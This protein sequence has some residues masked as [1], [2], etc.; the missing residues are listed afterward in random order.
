MHTTALKVTHLKTPTHLIPSSSTLKW[1]F[2][3]T[4]PSEVETKDIL[5]GGRYIT[6]TMT[7]TATIPQC[8]VAGKKGALEQQ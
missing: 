5:G 2:T 7:T 4:P 3:V 1:N 8:T 6:V